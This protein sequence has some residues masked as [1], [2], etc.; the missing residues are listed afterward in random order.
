MP[1][2][3]P[4]AAAPLRL[5]A[6]LRRGALLRFPAPVSERL[7]LIRGV[8]ALVVMWNHL[9]AALF[10]EYPA[11][12]AAHAGLAARLVYFATGFGHAAVVVFFVLSGLLIS[13][14]VLRAVEEGRWS[15]GWYASQ[16]LTRLYVVL[17]PTLV[18]GALWD[19]GGLK[20]FGAD[21]VYT[22]EP[23]AS[24]MGFAVMDRIGAGTAA[25]NA[26]F[27]QEIT[28]PPFGSNAPLWS[29]SYEFWY[30]VLFPA[31]LLAAL[32]GRPVRRAACLVAAAAVALL[33][34]PVIR[35]YFLIWLLGVAVAVAPAPLASRPRLR[36]AVLAVLTAGLAALLVAV[37]V[38]A[39]SSALLS[40]S[41]LGVCFAALVWTLVQSG[42]TRE[43]GARPPAY[44][45][46]GSTVAAFSFT[47]YLAHMP[48]VIFLAA[49]LTR[50]GAARW[51]PDTLH[52]AL[53]VPLT[54]LVLAYAW[55]LAQVTEARTVQVRH[56]VERQARALMARST[57]PAL[58]A[59][60]GPAAR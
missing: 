22:G 21:G 14:S 35:V 31:L 42:S 25:A 33:V 54:L 27:L 58:R 36:R 15:W 19:R 12:Q 1:S 34:G 49:V 40:D 18:L 60:S 23:G 56:W 43:A 8:A 52:L 6:P 37:R 39:F 28:A 7:D 20:L 46:A 32:P 29:L 16:R 50:N 4:T 30:Y 10:V 11:V 48:L 59:R 47:L 17:V 55:A 2:S 53:L 41:A 57:E 13:A 45:R 26:F 3:I 9:R 38:D 51:Q 5:P 24:F 44:A